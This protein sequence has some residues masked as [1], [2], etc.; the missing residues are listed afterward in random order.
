MIA[1]KY[2]G[3][4]PGT[5]TGPPAL[6]RCIT[7]NCEASTL[8]A[9]TIGEW[10]ARNDPV[11]EDV[12]FLRDLAARLRNIPVMHGTNDFDI[13][14]LTSLARRIEERKA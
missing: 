1:C 14:R 10:N 5:K 2:C 3:N 6:A 12:K 13:D 8:G 4:H 7:T 11:A 9:E